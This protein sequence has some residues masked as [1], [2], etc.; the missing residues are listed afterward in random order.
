LWQFPCSDLALSACPCSNARER[1]HWSLRHR[2]RHRARP[3]MVAVFSSL[4]S[5]TAATTWRWRRD[6]SGLSV[7]FSLRCSAGQVAD[8]FRKSSLAPRLEWIR[9]HPPIYPTTTTLH[10]QSTTH[11][12]CSRSAIM[13]L[14]CSAGQVRRPISS[15]SATVNVLAA[16][17]ISSRSVVLLQLPI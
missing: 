8:S 5:M 7:L 17:L 12:P 6:G 11:P 3:A 15:R 10:C 16:I 13:F 2:D 1:S 14:N 9:I 4:R